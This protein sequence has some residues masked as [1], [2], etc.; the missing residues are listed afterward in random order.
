FATAALAAG[1]GENGN[2]G[3]T[4]LSLKLKDAP[5]DVQAAV[6]TITRIELQGEGGTQVLLSGADSVTTDLTTLAHDTKDLVT[7]AVVPSG[8]YTQLRFVISGAYLQVDN[9]DGTSS[10][11]ATDGYTH[12]PEGVAAT[13][14]L[15]AP[16]FGTSGLK[17][18]LPGGNIALTG[19]QKILLVD[20]DVARSFG[21]E[22]GASGRWTM[23][24]VLTATDF[25][26]TGSAHVAVALGEGVTLPAGVTLD[27]FD[28]VLTS[29]TDATVSQ[30]V[31]LADPN[32]SGAFAADFGFL[33]PGTYAIT[34][35]P[36]TSGATLA[37]TLDGAPTVAVTSGAEANA[38]VTVA[39]VTP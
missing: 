7:N 1:C 33:A 20:F 35:A 8:S 32:G 36:H 19:D 16:S 31:Q 10:W 4:Q 39:G 13:G 5:G 2:N 26:A 30:S 27:R 38:T 22:S 37:A 24:P 28:V 25:Q 21:R 14:T 11:Y 34:L 29:T 17:V 23:H 18:N 15:Q 3:T 12:L 9:G 6:V